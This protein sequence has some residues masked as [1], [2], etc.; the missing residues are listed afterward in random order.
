MEKAAQELN[1]TKAELKAL[2]EDLEVE[3]ASCAVVERKVIDVKKV[4]EA[5]LARAKRAEKVASEKEDML[6]RMTSLQGSTKH[7]AKLAD[8]FKQGFKDCK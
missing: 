2:D 6:S 4:L 5:A 8:V 1:A 7:N 3:K